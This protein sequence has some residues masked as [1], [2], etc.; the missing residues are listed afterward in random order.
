[1]AVATDR[2]AFS[3][4]HTGLDVNAGGLVPS[5]LKDEGYFSIT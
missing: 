5:G 3:F 1:V 4:I 2:G